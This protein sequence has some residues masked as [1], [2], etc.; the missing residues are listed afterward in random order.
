MNTSNTFQ[1]SVTV[2]ADDLTGAADTGIQFI[3]PHNPAYLLAFS[4]LDQFHLEN[5]DVLSVYTRSRNLNP[6]KAGKRAGR[7]A[8]QLKQLHP[9]LIYL[10]LDS[11]LRGNVAEELGAILAALQV[12]ACFL[13]PAFPD[14]GRTTVHG[15]HLLHGVPVAETEMAEDPLSPVRESDLVTLL[16]RK[17][18]CKVGRIDIDDYAHGHLFIQEKIADLLDQGCLYIIFDAERQHQL[19]MVAKSGLSCSRDIIFAGSAGL[20][21]SLADRLHRGVISRQN[22]PLPA[23]A[24][25]HMLWICGTASEKTAEQIQQLLAESDCT[26]MALDA[27]ALAGMNGKMCN[28]LG[29]DAAVALKTRSMAV[30]ISKRSGH[31][32]AV[33][34]EEV[35]QGLTRLIL[36]ILSRQK[37]GCIFLSGGDTADAVLNAAGVQ[38]IELDQELLS[39]IV[40]GR[41]FGGLLDKVPVVTKA[42]S[43]GTPD[44]LLQVLKK[45]VLD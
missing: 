33:K 16:T 21:A 39:G 13:A 20:A 23:S 41:C 44:I 14:Q 12:Q 25:M 19:D 34:P 1:K 45:N 7:T 6:D 36:E 31:G 5:P 30:H 11:C 18:S 38:Y 9:G 43:F 2:L 17:N 8:T 42:G 27:G 32:F 29:S 22:P 26:D 10:K 24:K 37:P 40:R 4:E 35:L 28:Q 3:Q 15:I